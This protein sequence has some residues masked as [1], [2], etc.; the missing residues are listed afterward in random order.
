MSTLE[1]ASHTPQP[2]KSF[3]FPDSAL[4]YR[5]WGFASFDTPT[6]VNSAIPTY[7]G[8]FRYAISSKQ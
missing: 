3:S 5:F 4:R 7:G 8:F 6:E 1:A 2:A